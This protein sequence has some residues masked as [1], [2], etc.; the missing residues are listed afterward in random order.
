MS[1]HVVFNEIVYPHSQYSSSSSPSSL[2]SIPT[3]LVPY[4]IP[5][6]PPYVSYLP[7]IG[8]HV[9]SHLPL[10]SSIDSPIPLSC[11]VLSST[12]LSHL[13]LLTVILWSQGKSRYQKAKSLSYEC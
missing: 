5:L 4:T 7:P 6:V 2:S 12:I 1:R 9:S 8:P 11:P 10:V 13:Y 3:F